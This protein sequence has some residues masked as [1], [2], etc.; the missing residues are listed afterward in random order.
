MEFGMTTP[1]PQESAAFE[2]EATLQK[3]WLQAFLSTLAPYDNQFRTV[4]LQGASDA[5]DRINALASNPIWSAGVR[6]AQL[7]LVTGTIKAVQKDIY[8]KLLPIL[9]KGQQAEAS[10]AADALS[11]TDM[12][13]L[14]EAFSTVDLNSYLASQRQSAALGVAHAISRITTSQLSLSQRVY[15]TQ[16]LANGWIN[17]QVNSA[18][19]RGASAK[20]IA[21]TVR[22]QIR[23]DVPGGASYAAL[24]LG[25]TELNNAF[26]ATAITLAQDR[27]WITGMRWY[28]SD[29][30]END[31]TEICTRL[32]GQIFDVDNVPAKPHPQCR[33]Y[34][35]PQVE[36]ADVF[37]RHLTAGQ[38]RDWIDKNASKAA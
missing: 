28:T 6:T 33:C 36:S 19:L 31:P 11:A 25:R 4:L 27:P 1:T 10:T 29:V 13:Y 38:Y 2:S 9:K 32:N 37:A 21:Q 7:R 26:H 15:K 17:R 23:P 20:E 35:A 24:R 30:H 8:A 12:Q 34:V 14:R 18:I 16:A 22:S 5:Q 3:R